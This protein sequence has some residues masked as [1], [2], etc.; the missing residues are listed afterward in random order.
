MKRIIDF[1][2]QLPIKVFLT[3]VILFQLIRAAVKTKADLH[4]FVD[5]AYHVLEMNE[6]V[7]RTILQLLTLGLYVRIFGEYT[8]FDN[9]LNETPIEDLEKELEQAIN[10]EDY[11]LASAL[12]DYIEERKKLEALI[13]DLEQNED[14]GP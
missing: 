1:L 4:Q 6:K 14:P 5:E 2:I 11:E 3:P 10:E 8:A 9:E 12:R 7:R 13:N